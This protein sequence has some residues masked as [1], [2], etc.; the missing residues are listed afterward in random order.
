M[1]E[2]PPVQDPPQNDGVRC[3]HCF[4]VPC[5]LYQGLYRSIVDYYEENLSD[6]SG[7]AFTS[8]EIRF[9]LYRHATAW[10]HGFLGK[11]TR[12]ELPLCVKTEI[13]DLAPADPG[14]TYVGFK[15]HG[16]E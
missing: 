2:P 14:T 8:K 5:L 3:P 13:V 9:R 4:N 10:I 1:E 6:E 12:I 7:N 16:G 11:G 15:Q